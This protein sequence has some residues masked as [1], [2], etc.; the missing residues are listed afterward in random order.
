MMHRPIVLLG[1]SAV[2][3]ARSGGSTSDMLFVA[4]RVETWLE[5]A[6]D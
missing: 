5:H 3:L 2:V 6:L 1:L 4:R